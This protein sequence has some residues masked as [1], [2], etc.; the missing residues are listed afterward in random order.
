MSA[1]LATN[2]LFKPIVFTTTYI[3]LYYIFASIVYLIG[4]YPISTKSELIWKTK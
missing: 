1:E 2:L 4:N 3:P